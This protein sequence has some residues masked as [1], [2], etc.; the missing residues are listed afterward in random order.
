MHISLLGFLLWKYFQESFARAKKWV[1]ELHK[2]GTVRLWTCLLFAIWDSF[3]R[4][5]K[6]NC[7]VLRTKCFATDL[8]LSISSL[9]FPD[10]RES[11]H[12]NGTCREQS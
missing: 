6:K 3:E 10:G 7:S 1:Q 11:K 12:G 9:L 2:Q 5:L 8:I 4:T